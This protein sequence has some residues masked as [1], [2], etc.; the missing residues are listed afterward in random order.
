M[1]IS[2]QEIKTNKLIVQLSDEGTIRINVNFTVVGEKSELENSLFS[3]NFNKKLKQ[4]NAYYI[5]HCITEFTPP[6]R[7]IITVSVRGYRIFLK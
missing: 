4:Y 5:H 6:S 1:K 7:Y 3:Y 2:K